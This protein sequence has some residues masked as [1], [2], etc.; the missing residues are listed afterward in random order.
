MEQEEEQSTLQSDQFLLR[1]QNDVETVVLMER[2]FGAKDI[3]G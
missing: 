3:V 2:Q 1:T